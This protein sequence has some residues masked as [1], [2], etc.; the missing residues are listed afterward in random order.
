MSRYCKRWIFWLS[1]LALAGCASGGPPLNS[2]RI[3]KKFGSYGVAVI[4]QDDRQRLSS[5]YSGT[6]ESQV[7]RTYARVEYLGDRRPEFRKEHNA[8][9]NGASIGQ[10]FRRSG[11]AIR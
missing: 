1:L 3:A 9:L 4:E 6:G 5:L 10:T 7:T 2:D 8:I 11:W